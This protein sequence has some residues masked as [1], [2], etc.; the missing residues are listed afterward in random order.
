MPWESQEEFDSLLFYELI[1]ELDPFGELEEAAVREI[2]DLHWRKSRLLVGQVLAA[3]KDA[4]PAELAEAA[5]RG[6]RGIA[7]I[8]VRRPRRPAAC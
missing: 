7:I 3:Y 5:K 6:V 2:A 4:P 8:Y 1:L